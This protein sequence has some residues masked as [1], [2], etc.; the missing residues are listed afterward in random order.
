MNIRESLPD[1]SDRETSADRLLEQFIFLKFA[2]FQAFFLRFGFNF[3][4]CGFYMQLFHLLLDL[5]KPHCFAR[6]IV[7]SLIKY[8]KGTDI[9]ERS[10]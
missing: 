2:L 9:M 4:R 10:Y 1:V 5:N 7:K 8:P 6:Y 3:D